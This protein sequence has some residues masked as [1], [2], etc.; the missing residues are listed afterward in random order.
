MIVYL[1][2]SHKTNNFSTNNFRIIPNIE[3]MNFIQYSPQYQTPSNRRYWV[4]LVFFEVAP[5]SPNA[6]QSKQ[7]SD[8][9]SF[10]KKMPTVPPNLYFHFQ[11]AIFPFQEKFNLFSA[12]FFTR[13]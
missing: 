12:L 2:W 7:Q 10:R 13:C 3:I 5:T 6:N 8:W 11:K 1:L 9:H 4:G